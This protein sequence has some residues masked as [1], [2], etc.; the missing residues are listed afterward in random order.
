[1]DFLL[2]EIAIGTAIILA[3]TALAFAFIAWI[4]QAARAAH[5]AD[6]Q[7]SATQAIR[8]APHPDAVPPM[9][10]SAPTPTRENVRERE[11]VLA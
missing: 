11:P 3:V 5:L 9:R 10:V 4:S 6:Q 7:F 8:T 1:M 2:V